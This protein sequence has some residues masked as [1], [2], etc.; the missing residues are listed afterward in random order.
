MSKG[1]DKGE[2]KFVKDMIM[3]GDLASEVALLKR[4]IMDKRNAF[5]QAYRLEKE[6]E[7]RIHAIFAK[8]HNIQN[9]K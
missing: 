5:S 4:N 9:G 6:S 8:I 3:L 7:E 1:T 2:S